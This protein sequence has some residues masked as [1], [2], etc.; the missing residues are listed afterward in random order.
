MIP[1]SSTLIKIALSLSL[2]AVI[3]VYVYDSGVK[4][5]RAKW[6]SLQ[7]K[8]NEAV[9]EKNDK[10][11]EVADVQEKVQIE[12]RDRIVIKYKTIKEEVVKY[13]Q[14]KAAGDYLDTGFVRLHNL[15]ASDDQIKVAESASGV[16]DSVPTAQVTSGEGIKTI[17]DNYEQYYQCA[18]TVK[19]WQDFYKN[20][21]D[22]VSK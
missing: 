22:T 9:V 15:A 2:V 21:Q 6:T 18:A 13:E 17:V 8:A 3:G 4:H 10:L 7:K 5:E 1:V 19:G 16:D 14:T 20:L 12:Y 11:Q